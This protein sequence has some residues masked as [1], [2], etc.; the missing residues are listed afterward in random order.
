M[1][2]VFQPDEGSCG[3]ACVAILAKRSFGKARAIMQKS[4]VEEDTTP[5]Q[6]RAALKKF[7]IDSSPLKPIGSRTYVSLTFDAALLGRDRH[8]GQGHWVVWDSDRQKVL[9]PYR[10]G[11]HFECSHYIEI[12]RPLRRQSFTSRHLVAL[13]AK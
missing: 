12:C 6:L 8:D 1:R 7:G 5:A 2:T 4:Y 11:T 9:D 3:I 10:G 13:R